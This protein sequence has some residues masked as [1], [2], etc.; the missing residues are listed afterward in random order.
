[1]PNKLKIAARNHG[2][3]LSYLDESLTTYLTLL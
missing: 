2:G 3:V 1:M